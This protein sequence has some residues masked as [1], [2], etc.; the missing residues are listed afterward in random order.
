MPRLLTRHQATARYKWWLSEQNFEPVEG[1]YLN[2]ARAMHYRF[3]CELWQPEDVQAAV[4]D[5]VEYV[6]EHPHEFLDTPQGLGQ[7]TEYRRHLKQIYTHNA[8]AI[9][10]H[11]GRPVE[12]ES[13]ETAVL[14]WL[15][16][17]LSDLASSV[18][19]AIETTLP[20]ALRD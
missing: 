12:P 16:T 17:V 9:D 10:T 1:W 3:D 11:H 5:W 14:S 2:T 4:M 20:A 6:F 7:P 15:D 8:A 13:L 18:Y 19:D